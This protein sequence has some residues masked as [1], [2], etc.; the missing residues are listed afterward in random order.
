GSD[1]N[2]DGTYFKRS[3]AVVRFDARSETELGTL[4]S[5][6]ETQFNYDNGANKGASIPHAYIE[7]GGFRIGTTDEVFGSWTG[8]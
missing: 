8:Y 2:G 7:L 3:R 1:P 6:I 5:Y 4:R